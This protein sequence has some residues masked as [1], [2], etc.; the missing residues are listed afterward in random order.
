MARQAVLL[1]VALILTFAST[2][3][4]SADAFSPTADQKVCATL[5]ANA[6][7]VAACT[8]I[9]E[10]PN[11]ST[12]DRAVSYTFRADAERDGGNT[13]AAIADYSQALAVIST[14]CQQR[15]GV[16]SIPDPLCRVL[17]QA[18]SG[19]SFQQRGC[20]A[21]FRASATRHGFRSQ[22]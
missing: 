7:V 9:I 5:H 21:V 3:L 20:V 11:S 15:S 8:R 13:A 19:R 12:L 6:E 4:Y 16:P 1:R 2:V 10:A 22:E 17:V 14:H 18:L